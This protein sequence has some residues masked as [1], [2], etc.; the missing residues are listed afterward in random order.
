MEY[1][2]QF[3]ITE[4]FLLEGI[5]GVLLWREWISALVQNTWSTYGQLERVIQGYVQSD[6]EYL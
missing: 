4:S 3:T 6:F 5:S 1:L 2:F